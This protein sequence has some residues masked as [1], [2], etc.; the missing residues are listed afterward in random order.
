MVE[1][2]RGVKKMSN[3]ELK[4]TIGNV[5]EVEVVEDFSNKIFP[6]TAFPL[7]IFP[8][9]LQ[10][11]IIN[12][13]ESYKV[14]KD[15]VAT[16]VLTL[17]SVAIGNAIRI[18]PKS[19][20]R[21][22]PFLWTI[23][24]GYSG[25]GKTPFVNKLLEPI[26][27]RDK[28][29]YEV[30]ETEWVKYEVAKINYDKKIKKLDYV[31]TLKDK[32]K[33][34]KLKKFIITDTT[35]EALAIAMK[36]N[37]RGL[38]LE[39]D[40]ISGFIRGLDQY[41]GKGNDR[42]KYLELWNCKPWVIES[43]TKRSSKVQHTG[44][45]IL[46]G[47]QPMIL[48]TIF[49]HNAFVEG[50]VPRFVVSLMDNHIPKLTK[51]SVSKENL[52]I[53]NKY[54]MDCYSLPLEEDNQGDYYP[55]IIKFDESALD[56]FLDFCNGY[57]DKE[58]FMSDVERVFVPKL[59][60][61]TARVAGILHVVHKKEGNIDFAT[62][63]DSS[64]A[65]NYFAGQAMATLSLYYESNKLNELEK[66][67]LISL[68]ELRNKVQNGRLSVSNITSFINKGLPEYAQL[69]SEKVSSILRKRFGLHTKLIAGYSH[70]IWEEQLLAKLFSTYI[71]T[72]TSS[73]TSTET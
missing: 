52:D 23:I 24:V 13:S 42:Q 59:I 47:I 27:Q 32:P 56:I 37:P 21:E 63:Q 71:K 50:L 48:P 62:V 40:E 4:S 53:W 25:S 20:W 8:D 41:K 9:D 67:T 70:L 51:D 55:Q 58:I 2:C 64:K 73:T 22:P 16:V 39:Q 28:Y 61:Y 14:P 34:P 1:D 26:F 46:G 36:N 57:R 72:S 5:E 3:L 66:R 15:T 65:I 43:A 31:S 12:V 29:A 30:Y 10:K 54:V 17:L 18:S 11:L 33:K 44:C 60:N 68:Y 35:V 45:S 19:D 69:T 6:V 49:E 38:L 7:E